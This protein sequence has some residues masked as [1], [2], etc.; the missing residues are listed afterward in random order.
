M[1]KIQVLLAAA[2]FLVVASAAPATGVGRGFAASPTGCPTFWEVDGGTL[3]GG[4]DVDPPVGPFGTSPLH[5]TG[6]GFSVDGDEFTATIRVA[7]M[8]LQ[9]A[10]GSTGSRWSASFGPWRFTADYDVLFATF[11]YFWEHGT[12]SGPA[13]GSI[14]PGAGGGLTITAKLADL[15]IP[16][17]FEV[18][19][20]EAAA[21]IRF[22]SPDTPN[23]H[24]RWSRAIG[25]EFVPLV[26]CPGL[27]L[28]AT[29]DP[30]VAQRVVVGGVTLPQA[31]GQQIELQM[32]DDTEWTTIAS[33]TS[34]DNGTFEIASTLPQGAVSLRGVVT[35]AAGVGTSAPIELEVP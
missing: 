34:K 31:P 24:V 22:G 10:P 28:S 12:A 17:N 21:R 11:T 18:D 27:T 35:T 30:R 4:N 26:P 3:G 8:R 33:G 5:I 15:Q 32:L 13:T 7:D 23:V 16:P 1:R 19:T 20:T 14:V 2:T 6:L 29:L 9:V 25:P